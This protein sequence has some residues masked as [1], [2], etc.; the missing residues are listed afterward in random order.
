[1]L[2]LR[3][4]TFT[5]VISS[6]V[7]L[8]GCDPLVSGEYQGESRLALKVAVETGRSTT[9]DS[10]VPALGYMDGE[11]LRFESVEPRGEF[12]AE[13]RVDVYST[14]KGKLLTPL[15]PLLAP[16]ARVAIQFL[17]ALP[18]KRRDLVIDLSKKESPEHAPCWNGS[19][20][21]QPGRETRCSQG[22]EDP[23]CLEEAAAECTGDGCK[24]EREVELGDTGLTE[25]VKNIVGFSHGHVVLYVRDALPPRSW[26]AMRLGAPDGL[27]VG[28]HLAELREPDEAALEASSQ[29][30]G[31]A[32]E[33]ALDAYNA[34]RDTPLDV[35]TMRC[36]FGEEA[37]CNLYAIPTGD[38]AKDL[39]ERV[40]RA[41]V[42][43][44][45]SLLAVDMAPVDPEDETITVRIGDDVPEWQPMRPSTPTE[46]LTP[47]R[48]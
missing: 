42:E 18:K 20:D 32:R 46:M 2:I 25:D 37:A 35:Q 41:E 14:P 43:A 21:M 11:S 24:A 44:G 30:E 19:C 27:S 8:S 47:S 5:T 33:Q 13:F 12:P 4:L 48:P 34:E 17:A 39:A 23:R 1:M 3:L 29:C 6:G 31:R 7:L 45:C 9:K 40:A 15:E 22:D 28:Y 36:F 16:E 10:L 26:A 38:D